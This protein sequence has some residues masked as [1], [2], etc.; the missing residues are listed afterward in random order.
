MPNP[1]QLHTLRIIQ[2]CKSSTFPVTKCD[3]PNSTHNKL[4]QL[5][6]TKCK[7]DSGIRRGSQRSCPDC[8]PWG[9]RSSF[10][11]LT[12]CLCVL[13][14]GMLFRFFLSFLGKDW[15]TL[16]WIIDIWIYPHPLRLYY[17]DQSV[18]VNRLSWSKKYEKDK[19]VGAGKK[20]LELFAIIVSQKK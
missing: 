8:T 2:L 20:N 16:E 9:K 10:I 11:C 18:I 13:Q 6:S 17:C 15:S 4:V 7:S 5:K 19:T 12:S 3:D 1:C 14:G